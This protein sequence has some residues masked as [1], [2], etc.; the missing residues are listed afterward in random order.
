MSKNTKTASGYF[1]QLPFGKIA[2][3][4]LVVYVGIASNYLSL[5]KRAA[6][7]LLK[8]PAAQIVLIFVLGFITVREKGEPWWVSATAAGV[9][10]GLF[11]L[12]GHVL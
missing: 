6:S 3:C 1:R 4:L 9:V 10:A 2:S 11:Y 5:N 7:L 8:H 12:V